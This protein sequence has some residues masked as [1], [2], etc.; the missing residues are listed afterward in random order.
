[1][2]INI[3]CVGK[4]KEKYLVDAIKE[5]SKRLKKYIKL[6]IIELQDEKCPR[7]PGE[8][9]A[10]KAVEGERILSRIRDEGFVVALA[11]E[12]RQMK[13]EE[14]ASFISEKAVRGVSCIYFIIGGSIGLDT[15]VLNRA[16][17]KLSFSHMTFPHQLMR[18]I[19][20]EQIYRAEKIIKNEPYHK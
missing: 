19:L 17:L 18:V 1:M 6:S 5:Y 16:D 8:E 10:V 20:L 9:E 11:I 2:K 15:R 13:S 3:I 7:N 4:I 14:F 12:G